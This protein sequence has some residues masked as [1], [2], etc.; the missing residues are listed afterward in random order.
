M[1]YIIYVIKKKTEKNENT[2]IYLKK[3]SSLYEKLAEI[4]SSSP[5]NYEFLEIENLLIPNMNSDFIEI[6]N[7]L[8][9][10]MGKGSI[11]S[12]LYS[13]RLV[14]HT[15]SKDVTGKLSIANLSEIV[16]QEANIGIEGFE[17]FGQHES[18]T[19]RINKILKVFIAQFN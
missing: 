9:D 11:K 13:D 18:L 8:F 17:E 10:D 12:D 7:A 4:K 5:L 1:E 19:N 3:I 2:N 6:K 14:H 16:V 15:I